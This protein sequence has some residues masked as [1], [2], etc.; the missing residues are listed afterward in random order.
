MHIL[1]ATS[2]SLFNVTERLITNVTDTLHVNVTVNKHGHDD[3][4][5]DWVLGVMFWLILLSICFS[6]CG[7]CK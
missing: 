4:G 5:N 6:C 3:P 7:N 1:N 2:S